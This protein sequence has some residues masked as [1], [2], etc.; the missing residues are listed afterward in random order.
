MQEAE[1]QFDSVDLRPV[2]RWLAARRPSD[3]AA[4]RGEGR[5]DGSRS[6]VDRSVAF[7]PLEPRSMVDTYVDTSDWRFHR[8]GLS[9]RLRSSNES[10]EGTIKA[11]EE[12]SD[13]LR[14]KT[15]VRSPLP[16]SDVESL[17]QAESRL[18]TWVR[19]LAGGAKPKS[20]FTLRC[21]RR[22]YAIMVDGESVGEVA[23]DETTLA[24]PDEMEPPRLRRVG[25]EVAPVAVER[26]RPF[27]EDLKAAC[28]LAPAAASTY[29]LGLLTLGLTPSGR[30]E[31]GDTAVSENPSMGELAYAVLRRT[32]LAFLEAEPWARIGEDRE[33]LHDMR[34]AAR[35][36][37]ACLSLFEPVFS[38]RAQ[39]LRSEL[40][41]I[42]NLLGA[43]RDHD[44]QLVW[45][46]G[47]SETTSPD[48]RS[49]LRVLS[50]VLTSRRERARTRMLRS[51]D[52]QRFARLV[53]RLTRLLRRGPP[54][55]TPAARASA[56]AV[57]P[58]LIAA[59]YARMKKAGKKLDADSPPEA[60]HRLRI[61]CKRLRYAVE[62]ARDVYGGPA[63]GYVQVLARLQDLLGLH[64][65]AH[66][67]TS[68]LQE[69]LQ[70]EARRL[71]PR[72]IFM[73]GRVSQRY[74]QQARKLRKR[75][76]K[77]YQAVQGKL[78]SRLQRAMEKAGGAG[79][80]AP[81]PA[82][83]PP[84]PLPTPPVEA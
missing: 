58:G 2:V 41:W 52:S 26:I 14:T 16:S 84:T 83:S 48:D 82:I 67:A 55:R 13:G 74:D 19:S 81:W 15:E 71:P 72:A 29:E 80:A 64:Q 43:V 38:G 66:V 6:A 73:M 61:R 45:L 4:A 1:W 62:S 59:R 51:L 20:L 21:Q 69:L 44:T 42:G 50:E 63:V 12:S 53:A 23:L 31:L 75:F 8:A 33:A 39:A 18:G 79:G 9:V 27:V 17:M 54:K 57:F 76:P 60:Y 35:R 3:A 11:L 32:F 37:R 70:R 10:S 34:V 30:P 65:D 7:V 36:M 78:W 24:Q 68:R 77:L 46:A 40:R 25:V 56:A 47:W 28:R 22:P 49:S 5:G